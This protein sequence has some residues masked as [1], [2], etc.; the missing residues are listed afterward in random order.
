LVT[1]L[2][3]AWCE[4]T[5]RA[6]YVWD[7]GMPKWLAPLEQ[8]VRSLHPERLFLGRHKFAHFRLW[9]RE[10]LAGIVRDLLSG[11]QA[12]GFLPGATARVVEEHLTGRANR[13]RELHQ[14]ITL[15]LI[16]SEI[17]QSSS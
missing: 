17:L 15:R 6:E 10:P 9:Y 12:P 8:R 3:A 13:T 7:Y 5:A 14:L 4:T 16:E 2:N 1:P 11:F